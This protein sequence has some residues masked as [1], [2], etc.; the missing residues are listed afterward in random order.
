M[1]LLVDVNLS[2]AWA[3]SLRAAGWE[4]VHWSILGGPRATDA[5]IMR[6]ADKVAPSEIQDVDWVLDLEDIEKDTSRVLRFVQ[7][8]EK[9][10]SSTKAKFFPGDVLYGKLRPY[11]NKVVLAPRR[12]FCTTEIVPVRSRGVILPT[13]LCVFLRSPDFVAYAVSKSYGM[14]MPRLGTD[15]AERA[16]IA[17]P[18]PEEQRRIAA[19]VDEL[20]A[21]CDAL[22]A[23]LTAAQTAATRLL[24]ATL[25]Q[26]LEN[27]GHE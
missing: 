3:H 17:V 7:F 10:S 23:R 5:E 14:N 4:A 20:L 8:R 12:G 27:H 15:D 24:D 18:P 25:N 1:K 13:Y 6:A 11:L 21:L 9:Q 19:K 16:W 22:Q 26:L 2:P